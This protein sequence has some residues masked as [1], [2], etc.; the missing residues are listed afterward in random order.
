MTLSKMHFGRAPM[1]CNKLSRVAARILTVD[2]I[3]IETLCAARLERTFIAR[4]LDAGLL[5]PPGYLDWEDE[6]GQAIESRARAIARC[7]HGA[8]AN[9]RLDRR[10]LRLESVRGRLSAW[11]NGIFIRP[12][13]VGASRSAEGLWNWSACEFTGK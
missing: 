9:L 11:Q 1:L 10:K 6:S 3:Q 2:E 7:P 4:A 5:P 13:A 12:N 8:R